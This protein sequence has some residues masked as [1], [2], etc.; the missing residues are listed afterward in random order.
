MCVAFRAA[1]QSSS[2]SSSSSSLAAA[3]F[4]RQHITS[5]SSSSSSFSCP[6]SDHSR[7]LATTFLCA[8]VSSRLTKLVGRSAGW[9]AGCWR[10]GRADTQLTLVCVCVCVRQTAAPIAHRCWLGQQ[11]CSLECRECSSVITH[12]QPDSHTGL[13]L[14]LNQFRSGIT[15]RRSSAGWLASWPTYKETPSIYNCERAAVSEYPYKLVLFRSFVHQSPP[16]RSC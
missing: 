7:S 6:S 14:W 2:S 10:D 1:F 16:A 13:A 12:S 3:A 5:P 15:P 9:L 8:C 11:L 4:G